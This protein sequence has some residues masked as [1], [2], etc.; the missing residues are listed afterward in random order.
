MSGLES[1]AFDW[2]SLF[3]LIIQW[4]SKFFASLH[5]EY[6]ANRAKDELIIIDLLHLLNDLMLVQFNS[7]HFY[8]YVW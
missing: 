4:V 1:S 7:F 6:R 2:S 3:L 5:E 8:F